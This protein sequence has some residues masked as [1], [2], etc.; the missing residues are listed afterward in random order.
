MD[1]MN[2]NGQQTG[3]QDQ[4]FETV[5]GQGNFDPSVLAKELVPL[6][7]AAGAL[8]V[9]DGA[10][11]GDG[12]INSKELI[13]EIDPSEVNDLAAD[14]AKLEELIAL[15]TLENDEEQAKAIQ[16]RIQQ[17]IDDLEAKHAET[18]KKIQ[19]AVDKAVEQA[20]AAERN[21]I[22]G[23]IMTSL[24]LVAAGVSIVM[25]AGA[26]APSAVMIAAC[27]L[28]CTGSAIG[29][30]T[31][32]LE[33]AGTMDKIIEHYAEEYAKEHDVTLA[34][35][36]Q[37]MQQRAQIT[38]MVIQGA[39]AL[40]SLGCGIASMVS[41][42]KSAAQAATEVGKSATQATG[43]ASKFSAKTMLLLRWAQMSTQGLSLAGGVTQN[44]FQ[45]LD[46]KLAKQAADEEAQLAELKAL[47]DAIKDG[48]EQ[49]Q[50]R[51]TQLLEQIQSMLGVLT[52]I[53]TEPIETA[54]DIMNNFKQGV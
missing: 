43:Q 35:A 49:D 18:L 50:D 2:V 1:N 36:K 38:M 5:L 45:Y 40:A 19:E 47:L 28:S 27:V 42:A 51:L 15:L 17:K 21:K 25:T 13:P 39:L 23:W 8:V 4:L 10:N 7:Q 30:T 26:A 48:I 53:F 3:L 54:N 14:M 46:A 11:G 52:A 6:L 29:L 37:V 12:E 34:E 24:A 32:I 33:E 20:K 31:Q 9:T 22:L 44:I 16:A 41:A